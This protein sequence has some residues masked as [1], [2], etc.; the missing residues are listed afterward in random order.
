MAASMIRA[1]HP[2]KKVINFNPSV[3]V[4]SCDGQRFRSVSSIL[5]QYFPFDVEKVSKVVA[6]K[7][8]KTVEEVKKEWSLA[9]QLGT[10]VHHHIEALLK[11]QPPPKFTTMQGQEDR[12]LPVA[13]AA[14]QKLEADYTVIAVETIVGSPSLQLAGTIDFLAKNKKT[15]AILVGDWKTTSSASSGFKFSSF[16]A[17]CPGLMS[18]LPN[19]KMTRYGLQT[20]IYG[21]ILKTEGY[22]SLID[23]A[24]ATQPLEFG[25]VKFGPNQYNEI[26]AEF[27]RVEEG[28]LTGP[29]DV[30]NLPY[31]TLIRRLCLQS[32]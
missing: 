31:N 1:P 29:D 9:A 19:S 30:C 16:D 23:D 26:T 17:A 32:M 8:G 5:G 24:I 12:Y 18:H 20:L 2:S 13:T 15:G 25:L 11:K 28:D 22:A 6:Q 3:H 7:Q 21:H 27:T 10:N 4:Y 14:V